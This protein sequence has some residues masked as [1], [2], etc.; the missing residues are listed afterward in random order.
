MTVPN[1]PAYGVREFQRS[2]SPIDLNL[3]EIR[4]CGYTVIRDVLTREE[5]EIARERIDAV[6]EEQRKEIGDAALAQ[7]HE[8]DVVRC[9]LAY[10][11]F[12]VSVAAH[13]RVLELVN[14]LL[15]EP[16]VLIMQNAIINRSHSDNVQAAWHRDLN[17][18]H[19]VSSRPIAASALF[20]ID[21]FSAATGA[22]MFLPASQKVESFPSDP[23][24]A[25]HGVGVEA[26][27]GSVVVF[28]SMIYHRGGANVS[29]SDRRAINHVYGAPILQQPISLPD[30]LGGRFGDDD[31]LRTLLGYRFRPATS[32]FEWRRIRLDADRGQ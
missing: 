15:G 12:F 19:F 14:L 8:T 10:D 30:A 5:L 18:Q 1:S 2:E 29:G 11:D 13:P 23:F 21:S 7:L 28:D 22:T 17:Y 26:P 31:R 24:V 32:T 4:S 27:A 20:C 25:S 3:E 9:A 16:V 6:Y